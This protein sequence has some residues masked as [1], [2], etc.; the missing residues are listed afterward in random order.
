MGGDE[1]QEEYEVNEVDNSLHGTVGSRLSLFLGSR[2]YARKGGGA[3]WIIRECY[4]GFVIHPNGRFGFLFGGR[5]YSLC[6]R[7]FVVDLEKKKKR[8]KL[9]LGA[10]MDAWPSPAYPSIVMGFFQVLH[11]VKRTTRNPPTPSAHETPPAPYPLSLRPVFAVQYMAATEEGLLPGVGSPS[12]S[13]DA[14]G[15]S[16]LGLNASSSLTISGNP[17][18]DPSTSNPALSFQLPAKTFDQA[19]DVSAVLEGGPWTMDYRPFLLRKWSPE[20]RMEQERLSS[21]PIWI[22]LPNLPLHLWEEDCLS[23]IGSLFGVPLYADS[24]TMRCS[25]ASYA[26]ICVEVQATKAFPDSILV[27]IAPGVRESFKVEYDWKPTA[28]K[29]CQTFGH[30]DACCIMKPV[31]FKSSVAK[32]GKATSIVTQAKEKEKVVYQW[33][34]VQR[35]SNKNKGK[36]L[37]DAIEMDTSQSKSGSKESLAQSNQFNLLQ[38]LPTELVSEGTTISVLSEGS[39]VSEVPE[40]IQVSG[41]SLETNTTISKVVTR[42]QSHENA[43]GQSTQCEAITMEESILS[44]KVESRQDTISPKENGTL[45]SQGITILDSSKKQEEDANSELAEDRI[46]TDCSVVQN[47]QLSNPKAIEKSSRMEPQSNLGKPGIK[48]ISPSGQISI[49]HPVEDSHHISSTSQ[50]SQRPAPTR[51]SGRKKKSTYKEANS[52]LQPKSDQ[53]V[54]QGNPKKEQQQNESPASDQGLSSLPGN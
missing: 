41:M 31:S 38:N 28:C 3:L 1:I 17:I 11:K 50:N 13:L 47:K 4:G 52:L 49:T 21:I 33:Q 42:A 46:G 36:L 24:A 27:D 9:E 54:L 43:Q 10:Y 15:V 39:S 32:G 2:S 16:P 51:K 23:R 25:R 45:A 37:S 19:E 53:H 30:D 29:F 26:R 40:D 48:G 7:V 8:D 34:E 6:F 18:T 5:L 20:V 22:R 35:T 12:D 44:D 14:A